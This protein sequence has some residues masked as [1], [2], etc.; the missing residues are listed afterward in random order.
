M[1]TRRRNGG[2]GGSGILGDVK[3]AGRHVL[4]TGASR[5]IGAELAIRFADKGARLCLVARASKELTDL[6]DRL[7]APPYAADLGDPAQVHGLIARVEAGA[8][9]VDVLV[10]NAGVD[11]TGEFMRQDWTDIEALYRLNLLT[12]VELCHQVLPGMLARG[13]GHIVNMS[14]LASVTTFPGLSVYS[15][16]KAGLSHFTASLRADLRGRQVKTTLVELGPVSTGLL[17]SAKDYRPVDDSFARAY[18]LHLLSELDAPA[19]AAR[20][21]SAVRRRRRHVR[22][23][24]RAALAAQVVEAPRRATELLLT[25]IEH[26]PPP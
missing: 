19:V 11:T 16:S 10:N 13:F 8:G 4:I 21:V 25:G 22:L 2:V 24:W 7:S 1:P 9:P 18:R 17:A 6:A 26:Q 20:V 12:P 5:G 3:L 15:S 23:P 14:S